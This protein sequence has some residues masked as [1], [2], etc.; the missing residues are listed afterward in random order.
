[1]PFQEK[2]HDNAYLNIYQYFCKKQMKLSQQNQAESKSKVM[3]PQVLTQSLLQMYTTG[4]ELQQK[5][6]KIMDY[7]SCNED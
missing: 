2:Y 4:L 5:L 6:D 1:M 3:K 7:D